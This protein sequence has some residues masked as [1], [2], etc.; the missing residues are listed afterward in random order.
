MIDRSA[1]PQNSYEIMQKL[2]VQDKMSIKEIASLL[3]ISKK[4]VDIKLAEFNLK[5]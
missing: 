1:K 5:R 3:H 4:L 2:Y